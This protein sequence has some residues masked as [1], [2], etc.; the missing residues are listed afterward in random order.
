MNDLRYEDMARRLHLLTDE[1]LGRILR[2]K[3]DEMCLDTYNYDAATHRFCPLAIAIG[4]PEQCEQEN[5]YPTQESVLQMIQERA[6]EAWGTVKGIKGEFYTV[7]RYEDLRS[8][9]ERI[10]AERR[11]RSKL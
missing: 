7:N 2:S 5:V 3:P 8:L 6:G 9:C 4:I 10:I 11:E 1:E